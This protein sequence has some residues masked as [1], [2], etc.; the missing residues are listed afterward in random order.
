MKNKVL[1]VLTLIGLLSFFAFY[2]FFPE[3]R[4]RIG[5][6]RDQEHFFEETALIEQSTG[7]RVLIKYY[8][9]FEQM[10]PDILSG[11]LDVYVSP[12]LEHI[13]NS[14]NAYAIAAI[15]CD[16]ILAGSFR[17]T[18]S[19][20]GIS[21]DYI[22]TMLLHY[23]AELKNKK[24][25]VLR[26]REHEKKHFLNEE[27]IDFAVFRNT[28]PKELLVSGFSPVTRLSNIGL[29][30]DV[31]CVKKELVYKHDLLVES[32]FLS[33]SFD[34]HLLPSEDEVKLAVQFLFQN[35]FIKERKRYLDY[36]HLK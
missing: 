18:P 16:Y 12:L 26:V 8:D 1:P 24:Y 4:I 2:L 3:S 7:K 29:K 22:S 13:V 17:K 31:L 10:K 28:V 32:L 35:G 14:D 30:H 25:S 23:S 6:F 36:V 27:I 15:P 11:E 9:S 5:L 20:V 34:L 19:P 33:S 21:E